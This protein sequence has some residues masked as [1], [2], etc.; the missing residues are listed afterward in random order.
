MGCTLEISSQTMKSTATR[1]E[2]VTNWTVENKVERNRG[3]CNSV[4]KGFD[5]GEDVDSLILLPDDS[6]ASRTN[7]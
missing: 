3:T 6:D 7:K 1:R 5:D 2:H 4:P